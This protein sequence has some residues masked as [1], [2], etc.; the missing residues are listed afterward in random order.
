MCDAEGVRDLDRIQIDHSGELLR[1]YFS[2]WSKV[3]KLH[4][5]VHVIETFAVLCKLQVQD[6]I[7]EDFVSVNYMRRL[8]RN[9]DP[10]IKD[11]TDLLVCWSFCSTVV[12]DGF[13]I[14]DLED[15]FVC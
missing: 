9:I 5:V 4:S 10:F 8:G 15:E 12:L 13:C 2:K 11:L 3:S 6:L 1:D 7:F 14:D